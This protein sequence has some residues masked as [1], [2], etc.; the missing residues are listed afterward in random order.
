MS[1]RGHSRGVNRR[2]FLEWATR[3]SLAAVAAA[4]ATGCRTTA[5][6]DHAHRE[7]RVLTYNLHHGEGTDG[8]LD[9][10]RISRIIRGANP[11]LVALQEV[12]RLAART[13]K[14]DQAAEYARQ[15]GLHGWFGAAMPFQ[16][17]EYGQ[18]LLSRWPLTEP[19]VIRLPGQARREPRIAVTAIIEVPG[20]GRLRW[21]GCHLDATGT[22]SDR[23]EQVGALLEA[24][25]GDPLPML[26]AGDFN[27]R[28]ES[29]EIQR[30]LEGS[31]GWVDTAGASAAPT[32]PAEAPKSRIDYVFARPAAGW[33]TVSSTVLDEPVASD[34]RPL[35]AVLRR[36]S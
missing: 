36:N 20:F 26:L 18:A 32:I 13:D 5:A 19:R 21:S 10:D 25:A 14:V 17:G 33:T 7:L 23:G 35:L 2:A 1:G 11:D 9:L 15:T 24:F 16:G 34:H 22:D 31:T 6:G 8:R 30:L 29:R 28:P 12:D 3:S 27:A 4:S